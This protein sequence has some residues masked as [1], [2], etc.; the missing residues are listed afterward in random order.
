M[1]VMLTAMLCLTILE[2]LLSCFE[3]GA[4]ISGCILFAI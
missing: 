1:S 4:K 2:G 3:F